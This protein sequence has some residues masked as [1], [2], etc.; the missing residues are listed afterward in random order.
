VVVAVVVVAVVAVVAVVVARRRGRGRCANKT[1]NTREE[2]GLEVP[3]RSPTG[4]SQQ[5]HQNL[6]AHPSNCFSHG[7]VPGQATTGHVSGCTMSIEPTAMDMPDK[8]RVELRLTPASESTSVP[9]PQWA[10]HSPR[11]YTRHRHMD[12]NRQTQHQTMLTRTACEL[13]HL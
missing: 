13:F 10:A 1:D 2:L 5:S 6:V 12:H 9:A 11:S 4:S 3:V 8:P 7:V